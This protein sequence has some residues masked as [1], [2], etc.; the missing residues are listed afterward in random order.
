MNQFEKDIRKTPLAGFFD[1]NPA[2]LTRDRD[3]EKKER[4]FLLDCFGGFE[5][6]HFVA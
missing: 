2:L 1:P 4:P 3:C 5:R 6:S